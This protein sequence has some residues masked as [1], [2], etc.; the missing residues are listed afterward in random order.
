MG[1]DT[2]LPY[3]APFRTLSPIWLYDQQDRNKKILLSG[4]R[5]NLEQALDQLIG[6]RE[7]KVGLGELL[8]RQAIST[9]MDHCS[10]RL[11]SRLIDTS[12][13]LD[14]LCNFLAAFGQEFADCRQE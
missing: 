7:I 14:H 3:Y 11:R 13:F 5:C 4:R 2:F 8:Q 10:H 6:C 9:C 12:T 1:P